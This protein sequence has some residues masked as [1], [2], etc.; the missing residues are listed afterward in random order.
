MSQVNQPS[1]SPSAPPQS[2]A[3]APRIDPAKFEQFIADARAHQSLIK[4]AAGGMIG[5]VIGAAIWTGVTYTTQYQIGWM[6][7]GVGFLVGVLVR[8]M[9]RGIDK[10][11]GVIGAVFALLGCLIGNILS[12]CAFVAHDQNASFFAIVGKL[13]PEIAIDILVQTF[14]PIDLLF[15]GIAL[16]EGYRFSFRRL[17]QQE[18]AM[19][20]AS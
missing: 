14:S 3:A 1:N 8:H 9:G 18:L 5:A 13:T 20:A 2:T 15:Y 12:M 10:S 4:G 16:Y 19:L 17:T 6:A 11:F 7:V